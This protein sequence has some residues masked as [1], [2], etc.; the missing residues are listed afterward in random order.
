MLDA[1]GTLHLIYFKASKGDRGDIY[2]VR[3]TDGG[4]TFSDP[5]R[6]NSES[7]SAI[8]ARPPRLA[9]GRGSRAHVV[10]NGSN[11]AAPGPAPPGRPLNATSARS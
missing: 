2:Y 3:S 6:V 1:K 4:A 9:V 7:N 8:A 11:T 10:W 5:I